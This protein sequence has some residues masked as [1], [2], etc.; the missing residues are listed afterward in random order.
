[1]SS[2]IL[3]VACFRNEEYHICILICFHGVARCNTNLLL[4]ISD[5]LQGLLSI[6]SLSNEWTLCNPLSLLNIFIH[7]HL[8]LFPL[9]SSFL[10][11]C[12]SL[13]HSFV[14]VSSSL[15][16]FFISFSHPLSSYLLSY[17]FPLYLLLYLFLPYFLLFFLVFLSY[18]FFLFLYLYLYCSC[19]SYFLSLPLSFS[20]V[21]LYFLL[22]LFLPSF[23]IC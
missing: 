13:F 21:F 22:C 5:A 3:H 1:M 10:S 17:L 20:F 14:L 4:N 12:L 18:L 23:Q 7:L 15:I 9:Y 11:R 8:H 19:S 16:S 6:L 2:N